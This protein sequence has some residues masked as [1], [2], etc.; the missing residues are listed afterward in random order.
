[1]QAKKIT[2]AVTRLD[3]SNQR[4]LFGD[5]PDEAPMDAK[6]A[7]ER[8]PLALRFND[9]DPFLIRLNE[10]RLDEHLRRTGQGRALKVR[11]LLEPLD[12]SGFE[13]R[14]KAGGRAPYAPRAMLGLILYGIM[15]G[16]SSLRA[17]ESLARTDLGCMWISGGIL[18]DHSIIGR[19]IQ[20]HVSK[21]GLTP[22][23]RRQ[24]KAVIC[25]GLNPLIRS[26]N[27]IRPPRRPAV[28]H[29]STGVQRSKGP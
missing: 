20:R 17:L 7:Q 16:I 5:L 4:S 15:Q 13:Q 14:Y 28:C 23:S 12:W 1:M 3:T 8:P 29:A 25:G 9:P 24:F 21:R 22:I 10:V 6:P 26:R 2:R 27:P 19:F 18:P 11:E